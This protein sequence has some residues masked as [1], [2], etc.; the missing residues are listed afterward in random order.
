VTVSPPAQFEAPVEIGDFYDWAP[1][2]GKVL[3]ADHFPDS[4]AGPGNKAVSNLFALDIASGQTE[5][6]IAESLVVNARWAENGEDFA[7][8]LATPD[9]Y[10][11]RVRRAN[12][13]DVLAAEGVNLIYAFRPDGGAIAFERKLHNDPGIDTSL[14]LYDFATGTETKIAEM[15]R[16]GGGSIYDEMLWAPDGGGFAIPFIS[17]GTDFDEGEG[18]A[19]VNV[20]DGSVTKIALAANLQAGDDSPLYT[21]VFSFWHPDGSSIVGVRCGDCFQFPENPTSQV[22]L[23]HLDDARTAITAISVVYESEAY[24]TPEVLTWQQPGQSIWVIP[25]GDFESQTQPPPF[26]LELP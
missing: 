10:E 16:S 25:P 23:F 26:T 22:V 21:D 24:K 18:Y 14:H 1:N 12:G 3:F 5:T 19:Y 8:L 4:G 11:L 17:A 13:E 9:T 6:I 7:Y 15:D 2:T 20:A